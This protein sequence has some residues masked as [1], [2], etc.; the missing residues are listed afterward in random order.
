M[1]IFALNYEESIMKRILVVLISIAASLAVCSCQV[2]S[3]DI[4]PVA[5]IHSIA[6]I[7]GVYEL[8]EATFSSPVKLADR[9]EKDTDLLL[10][11]T[12]ECSGWKPIR[13]TMMS[14]LLLIWQE[15]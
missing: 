12:P 7:S 4:M 1:A 14:A 6:E 9:A 2:K 3:D 8:K 15:N 11:M 10:L 13:T 5:T